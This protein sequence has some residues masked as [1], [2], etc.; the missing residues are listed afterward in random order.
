MYAPRFNSQLAPQRAAQRPAQPLFPSYFARL[1]VVCS[2]HLH[3]MPM[4][5][6]GYGWSDRLP[7]ASGSI[8]R[9][10]L[11][12]CPIDGTVEVYAQHS[13]TGQPFLLRTL[14]AAQMSGTNARSAAYAN[15]APAQRAAR[16]PFY[17]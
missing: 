2:R 9:V 12:R 4:Q 5:F 6:V 1:P 13:R 10:A 8:Q 7:A 14:S 3:A 15:I 16:H 11:Y 17:A